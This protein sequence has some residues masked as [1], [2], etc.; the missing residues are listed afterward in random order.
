MIW[1]RLSAFFLSLA[2]VSGTTEALG[3][4]HCP[5][6]DGI[7][8]EMSGGMPGMQHHAPA[9]GHSQGH[10]HQCTC[11]GM[12]CC[13]VAVTAPS[14]RLVALPVIPVRVVQKAVAALRAVE[15]PASPDNVVLPLSIGP[16]DIRV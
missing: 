11:P 10:S 15:R 9:P 12:S 8:A 1:R 16:P 3:V 7:V 2:F 6:H 13:A 14:E 4:H 5:L